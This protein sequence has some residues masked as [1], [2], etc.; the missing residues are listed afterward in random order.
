MASEWRQELCGDCV[1]VCVSNICNVVRKNNV[2]HCNSHEDDG[3]ERDAGPPMRAA[4][5]AVSHPTAHAERK[6]CSASCAQSLQDAR[7]SRGY[8]CYLNAGG[9]C[10]CGRSCSAG[11]RKFSQLARE[12]VAAERFVIGYIFIIMKMIIVY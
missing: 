9:R 12:R 4:S 6:I 3:C 2:K 11:S 7:D 8:P 1:S 10:R 5:C